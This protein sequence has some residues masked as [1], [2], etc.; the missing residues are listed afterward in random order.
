M[1]IPWKVEP[2][3]ASVPLTWYDSIHAVALQHGALT[4]SV[5]HGLYNT[6]SSVPDW[7]GLSVTARDDVNVQTPPQLVNENK[8]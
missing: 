1:R 4:W 3:T 2:C 6:A 8:L 5:C 7:T